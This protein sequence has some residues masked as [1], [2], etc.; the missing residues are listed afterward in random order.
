MTLTKDKCQFLLSNSVEYIP[1]DIS[2]SWVSA[3][4]HEGNRNDDD[5]NGRP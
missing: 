3:E 5:Q 2:G 4:H 1:L